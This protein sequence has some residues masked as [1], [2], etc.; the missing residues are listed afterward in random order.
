MQKVPRKKKRK[1]NNLK[2][3][4]AGWR[5]VGRSN[6]SRWRRKWRERKDVGRMDKDRLRTYIF[7]AARSRMA[8]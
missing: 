2:K 1:K 6:K 3:K 8:D 5:C 4:A 7:E